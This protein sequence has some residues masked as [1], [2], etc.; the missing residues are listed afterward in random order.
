[1]MKMLSLVSKSK[2]YILA[3]SIILLFL[4]S[5]NIYA[6][7]V[8]NPYGTSFSNGPQ[9]LKDS[10][11]VVTGDSFA[12]K[13]CEFENDRDMQIVP[14]AMAGK[15]IEENQIIMALALNFSEKNVLFSI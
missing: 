13:F 10:K 6:A 8:H 14:Y 3:L 11:L 15:T 5:K 2:K 4:C 12:G 1:M 7:S 9:V